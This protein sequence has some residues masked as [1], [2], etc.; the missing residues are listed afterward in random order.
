MSKEIKVQA[1]Q[2]LNH[3]INFKVFVKML[4][5]LAVLKEAF[6]FHGLKPNGSVTLQSFYFFREV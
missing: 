4:Q 3:K 6:N 5:K 1:F 2:S